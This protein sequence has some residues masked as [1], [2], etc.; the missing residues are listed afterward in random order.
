MVKKELRKVVIVEL[1]DINDKLCHDEIKSRFELKKN[2]DNKKRIISYFIDPD[3][4]A[5]EQE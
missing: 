5:E 4:S 2:E 3:H 1:V